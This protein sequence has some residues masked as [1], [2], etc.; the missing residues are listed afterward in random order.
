MVE[1][2][3]AAATIQEQLDMLWQSAGWGSGSPSF[4]RGDWTGYL[5][6]RTYAPLILGA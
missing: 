3:A 5:D 6:V 4:G 1:L 2:L